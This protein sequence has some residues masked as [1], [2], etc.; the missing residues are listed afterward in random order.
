MLPRTSREEARRAVTTAPR[1]A[2]SLPEYVRHLG[3][4]TA[5]RLELGPEDRAI[6][7]R[8]RLKAAAKAEGGSLEI[9]RRGNT[10]VF[11]RA[12]EAPQPRSGGQRSCGRQAGGNEAHPG[13]APPLPLRNPATVQPRSGCN[14]RRTIRLLLGL[15]GCRRMRGRVG[16]ES[17]ARMVAWGLVWLQPLVL[18]GLYPLP[19]CNRATLQ[20]CP[21]LWLGRSGQAQVRLHG[22]R[23]IRGMGRLWRVRVSSLSRSSHG[24]NYC[25]A[26]C[27]PSATLQPCN[28]WTRRVPLRL[29]PRR[30]LHGCR[31]LEGVGRC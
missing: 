26:S 11:W 2:G 21:R 15:H 18:G 27:T 14:C 24:G 4:D 19:L 29:S 20:P 9:R 16:S 5:G 7:E 25:L 22:C 12:E 8:A 17:N 6:T 3:P 23:Q 10:V 30:R 28:P 31:V 1:D 13:R